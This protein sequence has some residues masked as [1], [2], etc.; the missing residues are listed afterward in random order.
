M[1]LILREPES[2]ALRER[3]RDRHLVTSVIA[4][5]EVPR[6]AYRRTPSPE[7]EARA[8]LVLRGFDLI[9]LDEELCRAS[10][11]VHS[12]EMRA[13]DAIHLVSALAVAERL[14]AMV[15]YDRRLASA[16]REAGL[17]VEAPGRSPDR[18]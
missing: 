13:L 14:E 2:D 18:G 16:A 10:A 9:A 12:P 15:V 6:E 11:G 4:L 7:V 8:D 17:A 3:I 5:A 1:K